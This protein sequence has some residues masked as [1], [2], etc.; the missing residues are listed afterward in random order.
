MKFPIT[1]F[2]LSTDDCFLFVFVLFCFVLFCFFFF[3]ELCL[4][5]CNF[6]L[7]CNSPVENA[8]QDIVE[9]LLISKS[10]GE[11]VKGIR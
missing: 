3:I 2:S 4:H 9:L 8:R 6:P 11:G 10:L 1:E 5:L 7:F